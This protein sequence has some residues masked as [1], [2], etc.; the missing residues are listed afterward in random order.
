MGDFS[1]INLNYG[2]DI[3]DTDVYGE[4]RYRFSR[5]TMLYT[6][7]VFIICSFFVFIIF[8][9][10]II[11]VIGESYSTVIKH[12][13][14]FDYQQRAM[15]ITEREAYFQEKHLKDPEYFPQFLVV[16]RIKEGWLASSEQRQDLGV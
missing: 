12:K 9:N 10:F 4:E 16:R 13:I 2:F 15:M 7:V 11:A 14:A 8:M 1:I 5:V 6:F 3:I